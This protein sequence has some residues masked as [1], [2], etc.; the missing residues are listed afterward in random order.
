MLVYVER[1]N[2][3]DISEIDKI[4]SRW[5][6]IFINNIKKGETVLI[7]PNWIAE[8]HK[9][10][11]EEWLSVIT[12][13]AII[14]SVLRMVLEILDGSGRVIITDGPQTNSDW[15]KIMSNMHP[16]AWVKMGQ[17]YKI[18]V[19]VVDLREDV[20]ITKGDLIVNRKKLS[21]DPL[22]STIC[23]LA[24]NSEFI[25]KSAN[26]GKGFYGADYNRA[27]TIDAH[28]SGKH[29]YKVART[30][31]ESDVFINIPKMKTH[32]KA[33]ITCSLKNLVGINTYKN[34]LP[35]HTQGTPSEGGDQFLKNGL[36]NLT[37]GVST[38]KIY[39]ILAKHPRLGNIF[40]P[41]KKAGKIL[42][43][44]TRQK[45]RS[46]SWYG[47]DTLWRMV[48][49]LNKIL[50]YA[51]YDGSLR[52]S[53][54]ENMKKY[55][56]IVD[57]IISGEGNGPDAPDRK[58][59]GLLIFGTNPVSVDAVCAKMMGFDWEKIPTINNAFNIKK[60]PIA[61]FEYKD[62]M[63]KSSEYTFD[64]YLNQIDYNDTYKFNSPIGWIG[65][66]EKE[67]NK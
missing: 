27:E 5:E 36:L 6:N 26:S 65:N 50:F 64:K 2:E 63:V 25:G 67:F 28:S 38:R 3:Y 34:W 54:S 24:E 7:K 31:I 22:G 1:C 49:D 20:W 53:K 13:P 51:N 58:N 48:L 57:A 23:N 52:T 62:I 14:T 33:G 59:T 41:I 42:F 66:I 10:N 9:Y 29:L 35:H 47:N 39:N 18:D 56:S 15:E 37:E 16:E 44:D 19:S 55:I 45:I 40:I 21:G 46:G 12:N 4:L 43:G 61:K 32:K 17:D 11:T 30:V 60:Y 8:S